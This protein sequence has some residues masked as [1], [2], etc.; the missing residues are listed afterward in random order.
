MYCP[1][2]AVNNGTLGSIVL[3]NTKSQLLDDF[4][5]LDTSEVVN[6]H[7]ASLLQPFP[8]ESGNDFDLLSAYVLDLFCA[9]YIMLASTRTMQRPLS[10]KIPVPVSSYRHWHHKAGIKGCIA[11]C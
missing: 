7:N 4:D 8:D 11:S 3:E 5:K 2:S 10:I 9:I 1:L 6:K